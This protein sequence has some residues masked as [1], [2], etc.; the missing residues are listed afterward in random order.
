MDERNGTAAS[1]RRYKWPWFVLGALL[2]GIALAV[3]WMSVAVRRAREWR[4]PTSPPHKTSFRSRRCE[5]AEIATSG[6]QVVA[7]AGIVE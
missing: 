6:R 1:T 7:G 2:L 3:L 4:D 5:T